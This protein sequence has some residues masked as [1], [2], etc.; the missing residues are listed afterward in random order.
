MPINTLSFT[1]N[2]KIDTEKICNQSLQACCDV[3][4]SSILTDESLVPHIPDPPTPQTGSSVHQWVFAYSLLSPTSKIQAV[5]ALDTLKPTEV[6]SIP[7]LPKIIFTVDREVEVSLSIDG[8][9]SLGIHAVITELAKAKQYIPLTLFTIANTF[10]LHKEGHLLKKTDSS[11]NGTIHHLLYL[12]QFEAEEAMDALTWKEVWQHKI[13]WLAE[14]AEPAVHERWSWHFS[15]LLKDEAICDNFKVILSFD[16]RMSC[17]QATKYDVVKEE[18]QKPS[19]HEDHHSSTCYE[20][21]NVSTCKNV[22]HS[23]EGQESFRDSPHS[24]DP[25]CLIC[26]CT[27]HH[28]SECKEETTEKGKQTY[29]KY[30]GGLICHSNGSTL[31][32]VH[33]LSNSKRVCKD[34]HAPSQHLSTFCG[35]KAAHGVLSC[36]CV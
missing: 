34:S 13:S 10:C 32:I 6:K 5:K 3:G 31:C 26:Q 11:I 21:Y 17:L 33:N 4:E 22:K 20:P 12:L 25:M 9:Y 29:T 35:S 18:F 8:T 1:N 36:L 15:T 2:N 7:S 16:I 27:G 28:F 24:S 23:C 14:V 30:A 19:F